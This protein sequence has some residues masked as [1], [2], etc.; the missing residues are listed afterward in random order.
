M[1]GL[2]IFDDNS[3]DSYNN[4]NENG[5]ENAYEQA[6][7]LLAVTGA[8]TDDRGTYLLVTLCDI[9]A[10]CLALLVN[11][12]NERLLPLHDFVEVSGD[13]GELDH[14]ALDVL[15]GV[16]ALAD[17]TESCVGFAVRV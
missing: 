13:L 9:L 5:D 16:V 12:G 17:V 11:S 6:P 1:L 15:Y 7:P 3:N 8:H 14:L 4:G 10:N 2:L